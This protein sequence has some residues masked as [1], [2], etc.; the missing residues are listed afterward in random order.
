[1]GIVTRPKSGF[2]RAILL[3]AGSSLF[4]LLSRGGPLD[5]WHWLSPLP[6]GSALRDVTYRNSI[7]V[8]VWDTAIIQ[9]SD[10]TNWSNIE[11][12]TNLYL[13]G[14]AFGTSTFLAVGTNGT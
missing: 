11:P 6:Q 13:T 1:M 7:F 2:W 9:T 10:G 12:N 5:V 4:P 14:I 8:A 3:L